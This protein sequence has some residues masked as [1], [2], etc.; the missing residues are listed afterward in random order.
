V[1]GDA[2]SRSVEVGFAGLRIA[3]QRINRAGS[4]GA[5]ADRHAMNK[6]CDA[7]YFFCGEIKLWHALIRPAVLNNGCYEFTMVVVHHELTA[8]QIGASF[9]AAS[10]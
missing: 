8:D 3:H 10:I 2:F 4:R 1:A 6:R 9:A 5:A 7:R